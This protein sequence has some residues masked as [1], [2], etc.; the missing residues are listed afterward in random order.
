MCIRDSYANCP[1]IWS[2]KL[3]TEIALST[4]ESEYIALSQSLRDVIPLMGLLTELQPALSFSVNTPMVHCTIFE[5]NKG[6]IDLVNVPKIRPRTKHIAL[7]YHHFR[8]FV[9]NKKISVQYIETK[10]QIADIFP[11]SLNDVQFAALR[12]RL[13]GEF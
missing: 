4:T 8:S 11:K 10:S 5:D 7:K 3:Q 13:I 2:S 9:R 6:C 12:S 1:I